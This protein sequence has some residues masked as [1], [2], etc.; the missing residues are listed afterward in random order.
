MEVTD[1]IREGIEGTILFLTVVLYPF[2]IYA[3]LEYYR[4]DP[5]VI[6]IFV[7]AL[8]GLRFLYS[9][10]YIDPSRL[11]RFLLPAACV[12]GLLV[13]G[14]LNNDET[15]FLLMP[16][17][18]S[19]VLGGFFLKSW[20]SPPS[21]IE[22]FAL[23]SISDLTEETRVYCRRVTFVWAMFMFLNAT[24]VTY[25]TFYGSRAGWTLYTGLIAY[26]LMGF[27]FAVEFGYRVWKFRQ[28]RGYWFDPVLRWLMP[29]RGHVKPTYIPLR[30]IIVQGRRT[31][32]TVARTPDRTLNWETLSRRVSG[33][34]ESM[35]E[36]HREHDASTP[37]W[38]L[39]TKNSFSFCAGLL[40]TWQADGVAIVPPAPKQENLNRMMDE[41]I[42]GI[43]SDQVDRRTDKDHVV[44]DPSDHE[45]DTHNFQILDT[46]R[47]CL[48]LFTSG[49]TG[50]RHSV[51]K[52]LSNLGR[53]IRTLE[54]TWRD[55]MNSCTVVSTASHQH[56]YGLLFHVLWPLSAGRP[57]YH[58]TTVYP[59]DIVDAVRS[60]EGDEVCLVSTPAHLQ[61]L[62]K[63]ENVELI[64]SK[65][66][67]IFS[68]GGV[69][70]DET[71]RGIRNTFGH[72]A[73]EVFGSTE[74]GGIAWR[75]R[76]GKP[77]PWSP[78]DPVS[79]R[80]EDTLHVE[81]PFVH[82]ELTSSDGW[83]ETD[84]RCQ[85]TGEGFTFQ[86][87]ADREVNI[88]DKRVSLD[89]LEQVLEEHPFVE[90]ARTVS[91]ERSGFDSTRTVIA[92][93]VKLTE[94]GKEHRSNDGK[95]SLD[96]RLREQLHSR[97]AQ[98]AVPKLWRYVN[99]FPRS[100]RGKITAEEI[101]SLFERSEN[102]RET[103]E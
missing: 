72:A 54:E 17:F 65:V 44:L 27:I 22:S 85:S 49:S 74:T 18:I 59:A 31:D 79:K 45:D 91:V 37:R 25:L 39:T 71:A 3:G 84:D 43:I 90:R 35:R 4:L 67:V 86:G 100:P 38:L 83:Y 33:L 47:T 41:E 95:K 80:I 58:T 92:A 42:T 89:E 9:T 48:E 60:T 50:T 1:R 56:I 36:L 88:A 81:S 76:D 8:L 40:A 11:K 64:A 46:E 30:K 69:L 94:Q 68:S 24:V 16:A 2:A 78:F 26:L 7:G 23:T 21:M 102:A 52:T 103:H 61:R 51:P 77:S 98:V 75:T 57:F 70:P 66:R 12:L 55:R 93:A 34:A 73:L 87:R 99:Q 20:L 15:L 6:Y 53:E 19:I 29:P 32:Y 28:Y 5:W 97:F 13:V 62:I 101:R 63:Y 10:R 96:S 14:G 82:P